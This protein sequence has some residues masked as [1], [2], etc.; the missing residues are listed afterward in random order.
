M[1]DFLAQCF[2]FFEGYDGVDSARIAKHAIN[3]PFKQTKTD[4]QPSLS[5]T[6]KRKNRCIEYSVV[7]SSKLD[8]VIR[9]HFFSSFEDNFT[10]L[11]FIREIF[12]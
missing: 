10:L 1:H 12:N 2:F 9:E 11:F 3:K 6:F 7:L 5:L 4:L 8:K